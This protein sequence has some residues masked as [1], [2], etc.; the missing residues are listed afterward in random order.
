MFHW[1]ELCSRTKSP[2]TVS[3]T[4]KFISLRPWSRRF[5]LGHIA[6]RALPNGIGGEAFCFSLFWLFDWQPCCN[7]YTGN[8]RPSPSLRELE[9][10][11]AKLLI[12]L[13]CPSFLEDVTDISIFDSSL[14]CMPYCSISVFTFKVILRRALCQLFYMHNLSSPITSSLSVLHPISNWH[15]FSHASTYA[16]PHMPT[17]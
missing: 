3:F 12:C 16:D 7:Q 8:L 6:P 2:V 11:S 14:K 10:R 17:P 1:A 9:Q 13:T 4:K 5:K 15:R